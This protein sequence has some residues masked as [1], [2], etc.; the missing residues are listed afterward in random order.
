MIGATILITI[1]VIMTIAMY[2][3]VLVDMIQSI[4]YD[5]FDKVLNIVTFILM[6]VVLVSGIL[7]MFG[8]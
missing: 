2:T 4:R 5:R 3:Q 7:I 6:T 1:I 8:I